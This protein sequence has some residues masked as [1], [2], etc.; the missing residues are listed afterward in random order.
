[1]KTSK[2]LNTSYFSID[3][4]KKEIV[5]EFGERYSI[6]QFK[7]I[8]KLADSPVDMTLMCQRFIQ[9]NFDFNRLKQFYADRTKEKGKVK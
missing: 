1:M 4:D 3:I 9:Y 7:K 2:S 6:E 5:S 8:L